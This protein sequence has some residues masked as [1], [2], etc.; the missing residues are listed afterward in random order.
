MRS[1]QKEIKNRS[2]SNSRTR[3]TSNISAMSNEDTVNQQHKSQRKRK[4]DE[5]LDNIQKKGKEPQASGSVIHSSQTD[6]DNLYDVNHIGPYTVYV[7]KEFEQHEH[8]R[9]I[10]AI[11]L[12]KTLVD[13]GISGIQEISK[14]GYGRCKVTFYSYKAANELTK[15]KQLNILGYVAKIPQHFLGKMGIIFNVPESITLK[16]LEQN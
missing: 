10:N 16:D 14:I 8:R 11:K 15:N 2:R 6:N 3:D 7:D 12:T 5:H 9:A 4:T 13:L 1:Q